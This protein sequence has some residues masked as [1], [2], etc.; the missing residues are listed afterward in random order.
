MKNIVFIILYILICYGKLIQV[1]LEKGNE[2]LDSY[3]AYIGYNEI[4]EQRH[5]L[6][7]YWNRRNPTELHW[8]ST[9]STVQNRTATL[10]IKTVPKRPQ[11]VDIRETIW[12]L[13][14]QELYLY[15]LVSETPTI[16]LNSTYSGQFDEYAPLVFQ[17]FEKDNIQTDTLITC[18]N[19]KLVGIKVE[20]LTPKITTEY[21]CGEYISAGSQMVVVKKGQNIKLYQFDASQDEYYI[22]GTINYYKDI[23]IN[24]IDTSETFQYDAVR[25]NRYNILYCILSDKNKIVSFDPNSKYSK[26]EILSNVPFYSDNVT[27]YIQPLSQQPFDNIGSYGQIIVVGTPG[28]STNNKIH[29]GGA[30]VFFDNYFDYG[31]EP[32]FV[33]VMKISGSYEYQYFGYSVCSS[34]NSIWLGGLN[35]IPTN[36]NY[37]TISISMRNYNKEYCS[38]SNC[39]CRS[40][41]SFSNGKCNSEETKNNNN[42]ITII[43]IVIL[44][45]LIIFI[46]LILIIV[47]LVI[48][49]PKRKKSTKFRIKNFNHD[50]TSFENFPISFSDTHL[51]FGFSDKPA[52]VRE[53]IIQQITVANK[54]KKK[55]YFVFNPNEIQSYKYTI[56]FEPKYIKL[57][58]GFGQSVIIKFELLCTTKVNDIIDVVSCEGDEIIVGKELHAALTIECESCNSIHLDYQEFEKERVIGEGSFGIVYVGKYRGTQVAIKET[59]NF[60]WPE[61]IIEAFQ[62]EVLMMDK[63][64]CPYIINF[65]GAVD[66]LDHYSIITEYAQFGS[67]KDV[68]QKNEFN[69]LLAYKMLNDVAKGMTFLHSSSI[70]HRDLKPDNILVI[71]M[72][73]DETVNAKLSDFGTTRNVSS[74]SASDS[75]TKGIGTPLYMAP[76]ILLNRP[77]SFPI[78]VYA[79]AIVSY[80]VFLRK[81]PYGNGC[82]VHSWDVSD[83]VSQGHRLD[84][85]KSF[86][87]GICEL[88]K[89]CWAHDPKQRPVFS[90]I[91]RITSKLFK[92]LYTSYEEEKALRKTNSSIQIKPQTQQQCNKLSPQLGVEIEM[93][94]E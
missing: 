64:R 86:S 17:H 48:V 32:R 47:I 68:Y 54:T 85:P 91:D 29:C 55:Q 22:W 35:N 25:I 71:S 10:R 5:N 94:N 51:D 92:E 50:F 30:Y 62:K 60:S 21:D 44:I 11:I 18:L 63:M 23:L 36:F 58:P 45:V 4:S 3:I 1:N 15:S 26:E 57:Q 28:Y 80:E 37:P 6:P 34:K 84:F 31:Y 59:K 61:D 27:E 46:I 38:E 89:K 93:N 56:S 40:N 70:I 73:K 9:L 75:M 13:H 20:T 74:S 49:I 69:D 72:S 90:E 24:G 77:Y 14:D 8:D 82:F 16:Y 65:V 39:Q 81:I 66:T 52:P 67:L 87:P 7:V 76:E 88:I 33:E 53:E 12:L 83:F 43:L 2:T 42:K 79:F 19:G 41:M 78:D